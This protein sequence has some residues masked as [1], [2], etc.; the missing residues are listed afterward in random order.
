[1]DCLETDIQVPTSMCPQG[2]PHGDPA[3]SGWNAWLGA[4]FSKEEKERRP[5]RLTSCGESDGESKTAEGIQKEEIQKLL[6]GNED[7]VV[8]SHLAGHPEMCCCCCQTLA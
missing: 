6:E 4:P 3:A 1:M 7:V 8:L 5:Q 2:H